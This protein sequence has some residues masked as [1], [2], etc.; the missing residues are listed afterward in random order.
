MGKRS[1]RITVGPERMLLADGLQPFLLLTRGG[2]MFVQGQ[3]TAPP[4]FVRAKQNVIPGDGVSGNVISRDRG[5]T[6]ERWQPKQWQKRQ[7]FFEGAFLQRRDGT[8]QMFEWVATPTPRRGK[9][10]VFLWESDD[11]LKTL[12]GPIR[13][14]V[15]L[16][17]AKSDGF[18]D[19]GRPYTGITMH[20]TVLELPGGDLLAAIYCWFK[21]DDTPCPYQPKMCKFRCVLLRSGDRGRNWKYVSTIAADPKVGEEGFDEPAMARISRGP[22]AGRLVCLMRTGCYACAI[23]QATSDDDGATWSKPRPLSLRGVDPDL[24]E[25]HDGTLACSF[26]W[27]TKNWYARKPPAHFGNYVAFS[28]DQGVSWD[29][30]TF[31][32]LEPNANTPWTTCYT[33]LRQLSPRELYL[34]YDVGRW[35]QAVRYIAGRKLT[36]H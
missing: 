19:G 23:Y 29:K 16:P 4:G 3:L 1:T 5:R 36:L 14:T 34:V 2:T 11:E 24:I 35:G 21:G 33:T 22:R 13:S 27:R 28:R 26:G 10:N 25:L 17:Q 32:P 7:P 15:H 9:C 20:R 31:I 18:D 6:W 12:R 8:I 30:P